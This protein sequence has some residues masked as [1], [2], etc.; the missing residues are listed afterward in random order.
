[1]LKTLIITTI[2]KKTREKSYIFGHIKKDFFISEIKEAL[3]EPKKK[4]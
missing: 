3:I 2:D 4:A 1:M